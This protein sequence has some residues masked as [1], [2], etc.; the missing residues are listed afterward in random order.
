ML[1][2]YKHHF[3]RSVILIFYSNN[4]ILTSV[5]KYLLCLCLLLMQ[6]L[7]V[8]DAILKTKKTKSKIKKELEDFIAS[9]KKDKNTDLEHVAK[10]CAESEEDAAKVIHEFEEIIKN[11]KSDIVWLAYHQGKI[12][13][14]FRSKERFLN[15]MILK[16]KVSKSTI[17]FKTA[18][19]RLIDEYP[20]MKDSS[21]S[22]HY[23]KRHLKLIKEVCKENTG[24]FK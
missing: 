23:F 4:I 6:N 11:K 7:E 19:S 8:K 3:K 9:C 24:E 17:A 16:F 21:L 14:K 20:K 5:V 15:D 2:S 12:F 1:K 18:L 22:L 10:N 13:Q